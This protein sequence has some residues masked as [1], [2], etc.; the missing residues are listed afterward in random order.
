MLKI[1]LKFKRFFI[2]F[3]YFLELFNRSQQELLLSDYFAKN[4]NLTRDLE[5]F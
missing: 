2:L 1:I 4:T 3:F 5:R